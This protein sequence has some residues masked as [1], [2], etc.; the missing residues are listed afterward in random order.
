MT[1]ARL[2]HVLKWFPLLA[3]LL[4]LRAAR[5]A[6]WW[7][8][9][10]LT[11]PVPVIWREMPLMRRLDTFFIFALFLAVVVYRVHVPMRARVRWM[12][13]WQVLPWAFIAT[14]VLSAWYNS[15][16]MQPALS[17]VIS[18]G[19]GLVFW[20]AL[21]LLPWN[22]R[23]LNHAVVALNVF[24]ALNLVLVV[25]QTFVFVSARGFSVPG[26]WA[27]GMWGLCNDA[28]LVN[29]TA[30]AGV[31]LARG[32]RLGRGLLASLLVFAG[33]LSAFLTGTVVFFL[34]LP[35]LWWLVRG[36]NP[37]RRFRRLALGAAVAATLFAAT[38]W[39]YGGAYGGQLAAYRR[40]VELYQ[41]GF[42]RGL[43]IL[44]DGIA[45]S[46]YTALIGLGPGTVNSAPVSDMNLKPKVDGLI[47]GFNDP[48][49][50]RYLTF[51]W[52]NQ[53]Y[54]VAFAE[55]GAIGLGLIATFWLM[56]LAAAVTT[57]RLLSRHRPELQSFG[58]SRLSAVMCLLGLGITWVYWNDSPFT[59]LTMITL[60]PAFRLFAPRVA[61]GTAIAVDAIAPETKSP[62]TTC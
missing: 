55:M 35:L 38:L 15:A 3:P 34:S 36:G 14:G 50:R 9:F 40:T 11:L 44:A 37:V 18:L 31:L 19:R 41:P 30:A 49:V 45:R 46:P 39:F 8:T 23:H 17:V 5:A 20:A 56:L 62:A 32:Q 58:I 2:L 47:L 7:P 57:A 21:M 12:G 25:A 10:G 53:S 6:A 59:Y 54:L 29:F 13:A 42:I 26:D 61:P 60:A 24:V 28:A 1:F 43:P 4:T 22:S 48:K 52:M 33:L 27:M 16:P 51:H